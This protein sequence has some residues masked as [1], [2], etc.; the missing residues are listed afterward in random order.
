M[1]FIISDITIIEADPAE[2]KRIFGWL[3]NTRVISSASEVLCA[4]QILE[5]DDGEW[6]TLIGMGESCPITADLANKYGCDAV[7][8]FPAEELK[9][10]PVRAGFCIIHKENQRTNNWVGN[11]RVDNGELV[12][13][14]KYA[15]KHF[16]DH[17]L[18]QVTD[19]E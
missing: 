4:H 5:S 14:I 2:F 18:S 1:I 12:Q 8:I 9:I 19:G 7:L 15:L 10:K 17:V 11:L 13:S 6:P 3:P 16:E